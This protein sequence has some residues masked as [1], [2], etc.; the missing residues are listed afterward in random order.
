LSKTASV[1][2]HIEVGERE[3]RVKLQQGRCAEHTRND[4]EW[5]G[6]SRVKNKSVETC[7]GSEVGL[8]D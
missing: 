1:H 8:R 2:A 5:K 6:V 4:V 3:Q 7:T